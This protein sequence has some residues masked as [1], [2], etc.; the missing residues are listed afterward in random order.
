MQV[1]ILPAAPL[2]DSVKVAWRP[3]KPFGVGASPTLAANLQ[4][5]MS[6]ADG[7]V[8]NQE[9]AGATPATLTIFGRQADISWLHLSR[10]Q[11]RREPRSEHYRRLPPINQLLTKGNPMKPV[12]R[13]QSQLLF[14]KSYRPNRVIRIRPVKLIFSFRP[15]R[16]GLKP[17]I[18]TYE[19]NAT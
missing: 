5:V 12:L 3:V 14:R 18:K 13:Y 11:N 8:R 15:V 10:K 17:Q 16:F 6:A 1:R 9:A 2:P 7:L 19:C 4:G